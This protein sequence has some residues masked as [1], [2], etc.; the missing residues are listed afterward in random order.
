MNKMI[1]RELTDRFG[2]N[3]IDFNTFLVYLYKVNQMKNRNRF[4]SL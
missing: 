4:M 1:P 3:R 2:K